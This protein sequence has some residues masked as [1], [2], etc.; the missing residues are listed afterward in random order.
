MKTVI[1]KKIYGLK[2][3]H[4]FLLFSRF[5]QSI[6]KKGFKS[7]SCLTTVTETDENESDSNGDMN[8]NG[9]HSN[10]EDYSQVIIFLFF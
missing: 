6:L 9:R 10:A 2:Y 1:W 5:P 4:S 3:L 7:I 8:Q